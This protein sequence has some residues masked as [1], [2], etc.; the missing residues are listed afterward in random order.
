MDF[1]SLVIPRL[2]EEKVRIGDK[3]DGGYV[4]SKK[5]LSENVYSYGI[6]HTISFEYDYLNWYPTSKIEMFDGTISKLPVNRQNFI[7]HNNNIYNEKSLLIKEDNVLVMMDIEGAEYKIIDSMSEMTMNKIKQFCLELHQI[8]APSDDMTRRILEKLNNYF[9][10]VHVHANNYRPQFKNEI[11]YTLELTYVN[12]NQFLEE[13]QIDSRKYPLKDL[14]YPNDPRK[15]D[16]IL[17]WWL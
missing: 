5:H 7:F 1:R 6:G 16:V 12:K 4:V 8:K 10:L 15:D 17:D 9:Y 13:P 14:D 11:P 3:K 2:V